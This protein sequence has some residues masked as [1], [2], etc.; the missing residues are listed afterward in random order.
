MCTQPL[1]DYAVFPVLKERDARR[2]FIFAQCVLSPSGAL[3]GV[4]GENVYVVSEKDVCI[5]CCLS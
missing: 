3:K 4:L 1:F 2:R 5:H